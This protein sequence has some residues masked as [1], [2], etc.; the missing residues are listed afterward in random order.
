MA[1]SD[2]ELSSMLENDPQLKE[3]L[4]SLVCLVLSIKQKTGLARRKL[5]TG[6]FYCVCPNDERAMIHRRLH[7]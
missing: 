6:W 7:G 5:K 4:V 2:E 3:D 1:A